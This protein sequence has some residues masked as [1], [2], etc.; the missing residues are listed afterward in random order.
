M[1]HAAAMLIGIFVLWMLGAQ[2][3]QAPTE[4][5]LAGVVAVVCVSAAARFGG[6]GGQFAS[7]PALLLSWPARLSGVCLGALRT[8]RAALAADVKLRPALVRVKTQARASVNG[9]LSTMVS[10]RPG[11]AVVAADAEGLLVH[12]LNE[13]QV[14]AAM[15]ADMEKYA[16]GAVGEGES[17]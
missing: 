13:D 17:L 3:G 8:I 4:L 11:L 6:V 12:V 10:G 16:R 5:A 7:A 1:L 15:F 14:D 9:V 2:L